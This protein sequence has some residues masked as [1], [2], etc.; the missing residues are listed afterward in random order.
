MNKRRLFSL[1]QTEITFQPAALLFAVY[2]VLRG[3]GTFFLIATLSI[4]AHETAHG[5]ASTLMGEMPAE[6][7]WTPLG[8]LMRL[9][10]EQRLPPLRRLLM[11]AAGPL[12]TL[13]LCWAALHLTRIGVM[14]SLL[15]RRLFTANLTILL[16]NLLPCLPLDGGR[17]LSLLLSLV[18]RPETVSR[19]LRWLGMSVGI[20]F[21][22]GSL[23]LTW[24]VGGWNMSL[25]ACGCF[26]I[27]AA[28]AGTTTA[29]LAELR[30]LIARKI[31]LERR[32]YLP[33]GTIA[34]M[35]TT[36][37]R[38][39]IHALPPRRYVHLLILEPGTLKPLGTCEEARLIAAYL[40]APGETCLLLTKAVDLASTSTK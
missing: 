21:V 3:Q 27:Y 18:A 13:F 14:D 16:L 30:Q 5:L 4:L 12:M 8:A 22:L 9:E 38:R 17:M 36:P 37:L 11:L 1:G 25:A 2:M 35:S 7:E 6:I 33:A 28:C 29:A 39:V 20:L 19:I 15:G 10:D 40:N 24:L 26:L 32:G 34:A 31:A 23:A